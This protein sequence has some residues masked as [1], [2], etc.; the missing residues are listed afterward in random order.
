[1]KQLAAVLFI[2]ILTAFSFP[3]KKELMEYNEK[4][5]LTWDDYKSRPNKASSFKALT[6]TRISFA[7]NTDGD[8]L[9]LSV[10]NYF[11]PQSS[12]TKTKKNR[13]LLDHERLHFHISE[14]FA[15]KLRKQILQTK[16]KSKAQKAM[17]DVSKMYEEN[18]YELT[19]CQRL[20]DKETDHSISVKEQKRWETK[21]RSEL[22]SLKEFSN[23]KIVINLK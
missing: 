18:I 9:Q 17:N 21:I 10:Q 20:Y 22:A 3:K 15:R 13:E 8:L 2:C 4:Q 6:A 12:W 19:K 7:A 14:L 16:Y 1:M 11:E 23:P 5:E